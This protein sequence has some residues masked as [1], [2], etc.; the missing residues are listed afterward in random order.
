[1][2]MD[3]KK[4]GVDIEAGENA[5]NRIKS[6]VRKTYNNNVLTELGSF[7]GLYQV[8]LSKW[9]EPVMVA[10]TDG[11]GTKLI[12]A[13]MAGVYDTVG[14]CLV[15]HCVNDIFVQGAVPQYFMDYI[16]CS[17]LLPERVELIISGMT[18]ACSENQMSL[19]G[20]E[21]AEMPGIYHDDDFDLAGTIV[22]LIEKSKIITGEAIQ[23]GDIVVGFKGNGLHTNG[24]SLAR[25]VFFDIMGKKVDD[26]VPELQMTVAE[27]LL[28]VHP[29]YF[30]LLRN[31]VDPKIN[32]GMAHITGG[33]LPG[34]VKRVMPD[35]LCAEID[36]SSWVVPDIFNLMQSAAQIK[37]EEMFKAFNMG[38][39]Y[40]VIIDPSYAEKLC[41]DTKGIRIGRIIKGENSQKVR[42]L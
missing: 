3:Y 5:V 39:G 26:L 41:E 17:K 8:D 15:N 40:V 1:V 37:T 35:G 33:G 4:S 7:G 22:G 16:G 31:W 32:H 18:K 38:I 21:M 28:K 29:S 2:I 13:A 14:Q 25:K 11:V 6:L 34:N 42:I 10:S 9:K 36:S 20:G 12:V 24:Y 19:I 23:E 30:P 27:A